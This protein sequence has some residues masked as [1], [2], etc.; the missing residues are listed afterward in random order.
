MASRENTSKPEPAAGVSVI[1]L[2][3][4]AVLMVERARAPFKGLWSFP[5]GRADPGEDPE[6]T[7]R[8]ELLEETGLEVGPLVRLGAF[9]PNPADVSPFHLTVFAARAVD[10]SPR[11]N[12]DAMRAEFVPLTAVLTLKTTAG[13]AAWI[14]HAIAALADPPPS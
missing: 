7:A 5:G 13:A 8:R 4:D 10:G 6:A 14:A 12:D 9:N 1:V 11:A 2:K 3:R